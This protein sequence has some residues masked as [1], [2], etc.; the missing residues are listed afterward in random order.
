MIEI[1]KLS[2]L[3]GCVCVCLCVCVH[4]LQ[5]HIY[6]FVCLSQY[7]WEEGRAGIIIL[8]FHLQNLRSKRFHDCL[9]SHTRVS[10]HLLI[11]RPASCVILFHLLHSISES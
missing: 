6:S 4:Y 2:M 10:P 11:A 9:R 1:I 7:S 8:T 3:E 5:L